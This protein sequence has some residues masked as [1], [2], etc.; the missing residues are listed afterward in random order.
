MIDTHGFVLLNITAGCKWVKY[1]GDHNVEPEM[2]VI[3]H[4]LDGFALV[5][6]RAYH[7]GDLLPAKVKPQHGVAYVSYDGVEHTK[8]DFEVILKILV[9]N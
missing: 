6:G 2:L 4:D 1:S 3:G 7:Q 9:I 8:H 5:V